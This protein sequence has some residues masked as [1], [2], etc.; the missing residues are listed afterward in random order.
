MNMKRLFLLAFSLCLVFL[1]SGCEDNPV[2]RY[3]TG[4][5]D[6]YKSTQEKA[7]AASLAMTRSAVQTFRTANGRYP[8]S[9]EELSS[10]TGTKLDASKYAYDPATGEISPK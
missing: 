9:L 6:S 5:V 4:L 10:S 1:V 8:E 3:G 7:D 2:D